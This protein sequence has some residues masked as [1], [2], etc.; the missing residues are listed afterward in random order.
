MCQVFQTNGFQLFTKLSH[1]DQHWIGVKLFHPIL[2]SNW[3]KPRKNINFTCLHT[4]WMWCVL[5]E[6][7]IFLVGNGSLTFCWFM[8]TAKCYG[9][10]SIR[11]TMSW[12]AMG[13]F[14]NLPS[15]VWWRRTMSIS[16]RE[17]SYQRIWRLVHDTRWSIHQN[18]R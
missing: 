4:C 7:I 1:M 9:K 10:I 8:F 18:F 13:C 6:S 11:R 3:R 2:I 5:A 12:F 15:L 17:K 14:H 16:R